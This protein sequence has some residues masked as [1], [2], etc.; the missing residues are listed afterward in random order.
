M[1][2]INNGQKPPQLGVGFTNK[3]PSSNQS[4]PRIS[5]V[6][7]TDFDGSCLFEAF[8]SMV[9]QAGKSVNNFINSKIQPLWFNSPCIK[10][11]SDRETNVFS[12]V[13]SEFF[14]LIEGASEAMLGRTVEQQMEFGKALA[15]YKI[16]KIEISSQ[17]KEGNILP[18]KLLQKYKTTHLNLMQSFKEL[19]YHLSQAE[20]IGSTATNTVSGIL[21]ATVN[22]QVAAQVSSIQNISQSSLTATIHPE[23]LSVQDDY[24]DMPAD[25]PCLVK[26]NLND[27]APPQLDLLTHQV[28]SN[29][30]PSKVKE[31]ILTRFGSSPPRPAKYRKTVDELFFNDSRKSIDNKA[32]LI[33]DAPQ[34]VNQRGVPEKSKPHL[35]A[36]RQ[37]RDALEENDTESDVSDSQQCAKKIIED[38]LSKVSPATNL[39]E[40]I[41]KIPSPE[42]DPKHSQETSEVLQAEAKK[43]FKLSSTSSNSTAMAN[44]IQPLDIHSLIT[45]RSSNDEITQNKKLD[46]FSK[47]SMNGF[48]DQELLIENSLT[49]QLTAEHSL[50]SS[51]INGQDILANK[52]QIVLYK[53]S[54]PT[55]K[56]SIKELKLKH[57]ELDQSVINST[58]VTSKKS[59]A[60][61]A[62]EAG[63]I[64]AGVAYGI[65]TTGK[66]IS[67][68]VKAASAFANSVS[69]YGSRLFNIFSATESANSSNPAETESA[70]F[71]ATIDTDNQASSELSNEVQV[72]YANSTVI[73]DQNFDDS[74]S[75]KHASE[76]SPKMVDQVLQDWSE[77]KLDL[78]STALVVSKNP[79]KKIHTKHYESLEADVIQGL[80]NRQAK[81]K[82]FM[83]SASMVLGSARLSMHV[84]N[85]NALRLSPNNK[86]LMILPHSICT[87]Q[88]GIDMRVNMLA[89]T[90]TAVIAGMLL[91]I[92]ANFFRKAQV[93]A[94]SNT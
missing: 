62:L 7:S 47:V 19:D 35:Y 56:P 81:N 20:I 31:E 24:D 37:G 11:V 44:Y 8:T 9:A 65:Y 55:T 1:Q 61:K 82:I 83:P 46:S 72:V 14:D 94:A 13:E 50:I 18:I 58:D 60:A 66:I 25:F 49:Q 32:P 68:S 57:I 92:A 15:D 40:S 52:G 63:L 28:V 53:K 2:S 43:L 16:L 12:S 73:S 5:K 74:S 54:E 91:K 64:I 45:M 69:S 21:K 41:S 33:V 85:A 67:S 4:S 59:D 29:P 17:L 3:N 26:I 89:G 88:D 78:P 71:A 38:I 6:N 90:Q 93:N 39:T 79:V 10:E 30:P 87:K 23:V 86:S 70:T 48:L 76:F 22:K 36:L 77:G 75:S 27:D 84:L 80:K 51:M 42:T 34:V